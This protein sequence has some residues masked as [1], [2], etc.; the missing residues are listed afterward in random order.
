MDTEFVV[1]ENVFLSSIPPK[2]KSQPIQD[3]CISQEILNKLSPLHRLAAEV[4]LRDGRW[5]M[6]EK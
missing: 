5:R 1:E 4:A 3:F 2:P 6:V